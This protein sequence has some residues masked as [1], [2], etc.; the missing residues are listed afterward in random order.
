MI[1]LTQLIAAGITPTQARVFAEPLSIACERFAITTTERTAMFIAQTS[2]ES[3]GFTKLEENLWYSTPLRLAQVWPARFT[4][5]ADAS[6]FIRKPEQLANHVYANRNGNGDEASG[7]GWKYRGRS[8]LQITGRAN[9]AAAAEG[10]GTQ[11]IQTP[12]LLILP[13]HA[14]LSSAWWWATRG[15]NSLADANDFAGV[16]RAINGKAMLGFT[17]RRELYAEALHVFA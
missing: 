11:Y 2:H 3:A 6:R 4:G 12:E 8:L 10:L 7:D 15:L 16:T 5:I 17:E 13:I 14:A 9:Y 1:T